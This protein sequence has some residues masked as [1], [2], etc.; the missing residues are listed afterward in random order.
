M[1]TVIPTD[2]TN[3]AETPLQFAAFNDALS[4]VEICAKGPE[5]AGST[6]VFVVDPTVGGKLAHEN[7]YEQMKAQPTCCHFVVREAVNYVCCLQAMMLWLLMEE[8]R[9]VCIYVVDPNFNRPAGWSY[10][11]FWRHQAK[12]NKLGMS[13]DHVT[14]IA[15]EAAKICDVVF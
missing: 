1:C 14:I 6:P 8:D 10:R 4:C 2:F 5:P 15:R 12:N 3:P 9:S 7:L 11:Y 13:I